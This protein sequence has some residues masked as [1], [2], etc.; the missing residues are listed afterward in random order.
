MGLAAG[1]ADFVQQRL[2][3]VSLAPGNTGNVAL[4]GKALGDLAAGS[5]PRA[6]HEHHF[7]LFCHACLH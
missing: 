4:A 3:L 5:I 6:N 2:Q 7:L 1:S